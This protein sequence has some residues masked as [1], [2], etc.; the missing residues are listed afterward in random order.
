MVALG[1]NVSSLLDSVEIIDLS[2]DVKSC[3]NFPSFPYEA[4]DSK[5]AVI[6]SG[7]NVLKI[8]TSVIYKYSE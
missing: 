5:A 1:W 3:K 2:P 4:S 8:S 6:H 7:T